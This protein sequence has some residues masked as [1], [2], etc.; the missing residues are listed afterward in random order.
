[1]WNKAIRLKQKHYATIQTRIR[2]N[3]QSGTDGP[4]R[5]GLLLYLNSNCM[6]VHKIYIANIT[7]KAST[8][9]KF[10]GR[11]C[12]KAKIATWIPNCAN[13]LKFSWSSKCCRHLAGP[14]DTGAAYAAIQ[15]V[16]R[17]RKLNILYTLWRPLTWKYIAK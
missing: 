11:A 5:A 12:K 4:K 14:Q 1:M 13:S 10:C 2:S 17:E 9:G 6:L 7:S 16:A 8:V 3:C 15:K